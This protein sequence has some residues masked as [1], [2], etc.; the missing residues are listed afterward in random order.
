MPHS[1]SYRVALLSKAETAIETAK[2]WNCIG[3]E[4]GLHTPGPDG[5]TPEAHLKASLRSASAL[6][7]ELTHEPP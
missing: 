4:H 5:I 1:Y 7:T 2:R 6:L 3:G